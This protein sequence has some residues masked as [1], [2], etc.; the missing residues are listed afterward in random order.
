MKEYIV[1]RKFTDKYNKEKEYKMGERLI[2][3]ETRAKEMNFNKIRVQEVLE[4]EYTD[5]IL[6]K[7]NDSS[8]TK[9]NTIEDNDSSET[10]ENTIED[11][12]QEKKQNRNKKRG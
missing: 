1:I 4:D 12:D 5:F 11:N 10:K 8:E 2:L 7:N 9:E 3:N 6:K